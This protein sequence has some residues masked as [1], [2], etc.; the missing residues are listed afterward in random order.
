MTKCDTDSRHRLTKFSLGKLLGQGTFGKVYLGKTS[1]CVASSPGKNPKGFIAIK[2]APKW[3]TSMRFVLFLSVYH[4]L[5][6]REV[7][8][9]QR[10]GRHE[11]I[12][13]L[14]DV[15]YTRADNAT[16]VVQNLVFPFYSCK[17]I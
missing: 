16:N 13:P 5:F 6:S 12:V 11:N 9:L 4:N 7:S 2:R 3:T 8:M 14:L 15:F 17:S 1:L 10:V